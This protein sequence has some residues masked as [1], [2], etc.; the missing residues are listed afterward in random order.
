VGRS[1]KALITDLLIT[2][3]YFVSL[4]IRYLLSAKPDLG[5]NR[6]AMLAQNRCTSPDF[7][8]SMG[9]FHGRSERLGLSQGLMRHFS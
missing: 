6:T 3:Y 2:G 4:H 9:K 5:E 1:R 7:G 8:W